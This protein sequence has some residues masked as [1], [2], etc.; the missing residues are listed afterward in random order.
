M[1]DIDKEI[2]EM[3]ISLNARARIVAEEF[4]KNVRTCIQ[5]NACALKLLFMCSSEDQCQFDVCNARTL[6]DS[7]QD[8]FLFVCIANDYKQY[9]Q[10]YIILKGR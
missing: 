7:M 4:L 5:W 3:K 1:E 9:Y 2:S 8:F 10:G 6:V